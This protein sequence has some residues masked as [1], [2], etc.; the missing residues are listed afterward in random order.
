MCCVNLNSLLKGFSRKVHRRGLQRSWLLP[1][2]DLYRN[3]DPTNGVPIWIV[4]HSDID[5]HLW[6]FL[7]IF[8][9]GRLNSKLKIISRW[10]FERWFIWDLNEYIRVNQNP[11]IN[12]NF[13]KKILILEESQLE[14]NLN[15]YAFESGILESDYLVSYFKLPTFPPFLLLFLTF[16][17]QR[18]QL[19]NIAISHYRPPSPSSTARVVQR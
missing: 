6:N 14:G 16:W 9:I 11:A 18:V 13:S 1:W 17:L 15:L 2:H 10:I 5:L 8:L 19:V 12:L 4:G 3:W 7:I